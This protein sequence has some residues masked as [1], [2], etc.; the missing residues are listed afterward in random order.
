MARLRAVIEEVEGEMV[1][2]VIVI[3]H[4]DLGEIDHGLRL[5]SVR[6]STVCVSP[7]RIDSRTPS[8]RNSPHHLESCAFLPL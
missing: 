3:V 6:L 1:L 4:H 5:T 7:W 2:D 8:S